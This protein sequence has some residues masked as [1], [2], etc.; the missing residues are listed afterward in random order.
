MILGMQLIRE[1][2]VKIE[3]LR[4][5]LIILSYFSVIGLSPDRMQSG[6]RPRGM[7]RNGRLT[8]GYAFWSFC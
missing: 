1:M 2:L 4:Q 6:F 8:R 3:M 7:E 5:H